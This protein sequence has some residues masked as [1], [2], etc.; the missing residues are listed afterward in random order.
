M[1]FFS[2]NQMKEGR[3]YLHYENIYK[4]DPARVFRTF[5]VHVTSLSLIGDRLWATGSRLQAPGSRLQAP[6]SRPRVVFLLLA[7]CSLPLIPCPYPRPKPQV[8]APM[9]AT[10]IRPSRC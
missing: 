6:G 2:I 7:P 3:A 1:T 10:G 8:P 4:S 5:D 9:P